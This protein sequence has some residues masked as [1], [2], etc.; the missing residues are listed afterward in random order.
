MRHFQ[1]IINFQ[2]IQTQIQIRLCVIERTKK[3]V[4]FIQ[5]SNN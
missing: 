3:C 4:N 1:Q 5:I 2:K